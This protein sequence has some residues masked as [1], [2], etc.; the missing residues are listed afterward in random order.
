MKQS[1][2]LLKEFLEKIKVRGVRVRNSLESSSADMYDNIIFY[3]A[4]GENAEMDKI[5]SDIYKSK[6][7]NIKISPTTYAFFH[8]LGHL[9]SK[10]EIQNL[11]KEMSKYS[12]MVELI[13]ATI[14]DEKKSMEAYRNLRLE[15]LADKHAYRVYKRN[16]KLAIKLDKK[17]QALR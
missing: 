12:A 2:K 8:E 5:V 3:N 6:K 17:L 7:H 9:L 15:K 1:T 16:E 13:N 4:K 10:I 11:D 14:K